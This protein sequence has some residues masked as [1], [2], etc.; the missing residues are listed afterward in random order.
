[1]NTFDGCCGSCVNMNTNDYIRHKDH[2]YCTYRKQY[3]NLTEP[4]C[5]AYKYDPNK[6]YY[7][8][9]RRWYIVSTIFEKLSLNDKYKCINLLQNFRLNALDNN[10][11]YAE[12]LG[13]YDI[14]GPEIAK[15]LDEDEESQK[16]CKELAQYLL[17]VLDNINAGKIDEAVETYI[18]MVNV[19]IKKY[20]I[21]VEDLV[22]K[23][24]TK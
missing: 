20:N 22:K 12:V 4:K 17:L 15:L 6:D 5:Y 16:V 13:E 24:N 10:P 14:V 8:L 9:N 23:S 11:K 3:Y 1:M 18:K 19:L 7:D 2:C 21:N